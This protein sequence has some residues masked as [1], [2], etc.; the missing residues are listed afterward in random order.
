MQGVPIGSVYHSRR[1]KEVK[2]G[3]AQWMKAFV[4]KPNDPSLIPG[5]HIV[6]KMTSALSSDLQVCAL[7]Y[8][9]IAEV[10]TMI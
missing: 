9:Q 4:S 3:M 6:E 5:F 10:I 1:L 7:L 8:K 2:C